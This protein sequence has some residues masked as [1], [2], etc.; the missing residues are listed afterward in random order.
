MRVMKSRKEMQHALLV[1][2]VWRAA[3]A[4]LAPRCNCAPRR[5]LLAGD[6]AAQDYFHA[7][8]EGDEESHQ[9]PDR[10]R[11]PCAQG[12]RRDGIRVH[13]VTRDGD[14]PCARRAARWHTR[15][16]T[17]RVAPNT[18]R[19]TM[20]AVSADT[21]THS[22]AAVC[23]GCSGLCAQRRTQSHTV[24]HACDD[25]CAGSL[26]SAASAAHTDPIKRGSRHAWAANYCIYTPPHARARAEISGAPSSITRTPP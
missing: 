12:G 23:V 15:D 26:A 13:R 14:A 18:R 20:C 19:T 2:E 1:A 9:R 8:P 3:R 17:R 25:P 11:V 6:I 4:R 5:F 24:C 7:R 10:A 21:T 22:K 16:A